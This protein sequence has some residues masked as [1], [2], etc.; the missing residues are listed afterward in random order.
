MIFPPATL[1]VLGTPDR[2]TTLTQVPQLDFA[3]F[4]FADFVRQG[5]EDDYEIVGITDLYLEWIGPS[6]LTQQTVGTVFGLGQTLPVQP[7]AVNSSWHVDFLGPAIQ[8]VDVDSQTR[9]AIWTNIWNSF[10]FTDAD[11]SYLFLSWVPWDRDDFLG[12]IPSNYTNSNIPFLFSAPGNGSIT[13]PKSTSLP[14]GVPAYVHVAVMPGMQEFQFFETAGIGSFVWNDLSCHNQMVG[15]INDTF[16]TIC[17]DSSIGPIDSSIGPSIDIPS[18]AQNITFTPST[19][20]NGSTLLRCDLVEAPYSAQ[21]NFTDGAQNVTVTSETSLDTP[22][23]VP[24]LTFTAPIS[25]NNSIKATCSGIDSTWS[26]LL[27]ESTL[28]LLSYQSIAAAFNQL[29]VGYIQN[30]AAPGGEGQLS[31]GSTIM[32]TVLGKSEELDFI[33]NW[34]SS[35]GSD[36]A[37]LPLESLLLNGSNTEY[38]S[39]LRTEA[40]ES[41]GTLKSNLEQLFQ[42]VTISLLSQPYFQ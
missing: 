23:I 8:C 2:K 31:F 39:L 12:P 1:S 6:Q 35:N 10:S 14:F 34:K 9:D 29:F 16:A 27:E 40:T 24:Q 28:R 19:A 4:N 42:N 41:P 17:N 38:L 32:R 7:P 25:N 36:S 21:F 5:S 22:V 37:Y 18:P 3:T 20:F 13:G 30:T 15:H 33:R 11:T 26:C